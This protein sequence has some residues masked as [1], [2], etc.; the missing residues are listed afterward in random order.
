MAGRV[1]V[2]LL[3]AAWLLTCILPSPARA[4]EILVL[5]TD[6]EPPHSRP[7]GAGF[8]DRIILEAFRRIGHTVQLVRL[9]S[10]RC[11]QNV[12]AG[13]D[14]GNYV[15]IAGLEK[16][17][18]ELVLV[19]EPV[20]TFPFTAFT[21]DPGL[22]AAR[23]EDLRGRQTAYVTGWKLPEARLSGP[24]R[25]K[26]LR[27]EE[28]LFAMLAAGRTEV[29]ISGLHTGRAI[30]RRMGYTDI[31][32]LLPPLESPPTHLYLNRR[33]ALL[34]PA[35]TQA[36]RDMRRDGALARLTRLGLGEDAP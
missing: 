15:R 7:D 10:E 11:L 17:H 25:P 3:L 1:R 13:I 27:D 31:R 23:W 18:P 12:I 32:P 16:L 35:L 14:D 29:V 2:A 9:P 22:K 34:V 26:P 19:P 6:G 36:L 21:R 8:E 28:A 30:I 24:P 5:N 4:S 20:S 33:H